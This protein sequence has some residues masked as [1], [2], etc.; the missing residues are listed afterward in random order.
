MSSIFGRRP[1]TRRDWLRNTSL[2]AG[3]AVLPGCDPDTM[4]MDAGLDDAGVDG[5]PPAT[6]A[7]P[8]GP[9][10]PRERTYEAFEHGVASGDPLTDAVILWTRVTPGGP[11]DDPPASL[12]VSWTI[13]TDQALSD[14]VAS[15]TETTDAT[16]DWTVKV[17]ATGL[18][19]A[20]TYYYRFASMGA[21][22]PL[23]RT[24]TAPDG[25]T[26]RLRFG[27]AS[28]SSLAHGFFHA[29]GML[30]RRADLDAVI[31][32]GD[33]IYEYGT[34]QYG[35]RRAYLPEHE[36]VSLEDYRA[37]YAQHRREPELAEAHRQHPFIVVWDDHETADNAW[38][39]G[40]ENHQADEGAWADRV[41][42]AVQVY[43]E[44]MPIRDDAGGEATRLWRTHGYGALCDLVVLD[45]RVWGREEQAS[46]LTDPA[47]SDPDRQLL[48][49]DQETW[50][51]EQLRTS[52][53]RWKVLAQ[54][55]MMGQVSGFPNPD[56][57]DGYPAA[58]ERLLSVI[59]TDAI[60]DVVVL[61]GD[62]HSSWAFD[63]P[64]DPEDEVAYD[65]ATGEGSYGV[66]L[67]CPAVSSPGLPEALARAAASFV[68]NNRS[69]MFAELS[70]RGYVVLDLTEARAQA[71]WFFVGDVEDEGDETEEHAGSFAT[72]TGASHLTEAMAPAAPRPDAPA[73][74]E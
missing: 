45:T 38:S 44:W 25:P 8:G 5:G 28:C 15:G 73:L 20:T 18:S 74:A 30:A 62:I 9:L 39:G 37:R 52:T 69:L 50:L 58:R 68:R 21:D 60:A 32:L 33:Y 64:F 72:A 13:A 54:Q 46:S 2:A 51:F 27:I 41:A 48:G 11:D 26:D 12:D 71:D 43:R 59:Q 40:A 57:W 42:A 36:I 61:T 22:S 34:L 19:P 6:D 29:Y 24:R 35:E 65:P 4:G 31:H 63:L 67:V 3:A 55:V 70:R 16:R 10:P 7:G 66:E 53:A 17:D 47:V 14:V 49:E 23:G 56:Q 1:W